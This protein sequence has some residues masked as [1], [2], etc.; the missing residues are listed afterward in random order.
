[1]FNMYD[2]VGIKTKIPDPYKVKKL[3]MSS[4]IENRVSEKKEQEQEQNEQ[5]SQHT[6]MSNEAKNAYKKMANIHV[7]EEI[8]HAYQLMS[9]KVVTV[10][11]T[12]NIYN[13]WLKMEENDLKQIPVVGLTGK[14]TGLATMRNIVKSMIEHKEDSQYI[15]NAT[16]DSIAIHD[17]MTA[18]PISDIRRVAK[19][20]IKYHLNNIPI[21][22]GQSDRIVGIL[23]R[24][25]ILRAVSTNPHYQLW[26]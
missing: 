18:E 26:A 9:S 3:D 23:S 19:V 1:M 2:D 25:D 11:S 15:N 21:V 10:K 16:V 7:D 20:M 5:L 24:A 17:I 6:N 12:D 14:L 22:D 8:L 4:P 13:C